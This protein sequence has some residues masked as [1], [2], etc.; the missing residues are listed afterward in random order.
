M[1]EEI[2]ESG[3][4]TPMDLALFTSYLTEKKLYKQSSAYSIH[5]KAKMFVHKKIDL[6]DINAV[7]AIIIESGIKKRNNLVY[8]AAKNLIEFKIEDKKTREELLS[9]L[10]KT[11]LYNDRKKLTKSLTDEEILEVINHINSQK[12]KVI[13]ILQTLTGARVGDIMN[14]KLEDIMPDETDGAFVLKLN[15]LSK[16]GKHIIH[17]LFD[18][19]A[20][21]LLLNYALSERPH[22]YKG[23]IFIDKYYTKG[24]TPQELKDYETFYSNY[25]LYIFD[26]KGALQACGIDKKDFSSHDFRRAFATKAWKKY[27]DVNILKILMHHSEIKTSMRYLQGQ[28]LDSQNYQR[29][30]QQ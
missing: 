15:T 29:E 17:F 20:Q 1:M 6:K 3:I 13:A 14:L 19:L 26:L 8:H 21:E 25:Q 5:S 28:G 7:N 12:H 30:M 10:L 9:K 18:E 22:S 2:E 4:V 16:G 27:K 11:K 23:N 24:N